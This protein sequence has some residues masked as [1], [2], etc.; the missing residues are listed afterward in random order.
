MKQCRQCGVEIEDDYIR[1]PLCGAAV[2]SPAKGSVP[3]GTPTPTSPDPASPPDGPAQ[4][5]ERPDRSGRAAEGEL[6]DADRAERRQA[7][8]WLWQMFSLVILAT[9]LIVAAADF[10]YGFDISWSAYPLT[11]LGFIWLFVTVIVGLGKDLPIA[12]TAEVLTVL[13]YLYVLDLLLPGA[14]FFLPFAVPITLLVAAIGASAAAVVRALKLTIFPTLAVAMVAIGVFVVGL[15]VVFYFSFG[16][17]T[18]LSW[19]IIAFAGCLS[20]ALLLLFINRRLR[21]RHADFRRLFH[22]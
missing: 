18:V 3:D 12:Y 17:E 22:M 9:G 21:E 4:A 8:T 1:C 5:L 10:A 16:L 6:S 13:G 7:R 14:A 20:I 11:G 15:D 2:D 19:S